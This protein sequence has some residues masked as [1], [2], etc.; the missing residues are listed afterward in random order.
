M[1][2][3]EKIMQQSFMQGNMKKRTSVLVFLKG[4]AAPLVLYTANPIALYEELLG[5]M[6]KN[7]AVLVEKETQGPIRKV[8]FKSEEVKAIALQDEPFIP[9]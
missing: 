6:K 1:R 5:L 3:G 7:A 8:C 9:Q 2:T 4:A